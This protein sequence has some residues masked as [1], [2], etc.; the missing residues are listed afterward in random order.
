MNK[1]ILMIFILSLFLFPFIFNFVSSQPDS[2]TIFGIS[3]DSGVKLTE[4]WE[5]LGKNWKDMLMENSV[6]RGIDSFF[7]KIDPL[8]SILFGVEYSLSL[9][10]LFTILLWMYTF[11]L[12]NGILGNSLFSKWV[13]LAISLGVTI[14]IAQLKLFQISTNFIIGIFFGEQPWWA[15]VIIGIGIFA[16]LAILFVLVKNFGKQFAAS[17]KKLKEEKDRLKLHTGGV[18]GDALSKAVGGRK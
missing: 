11:F 1:K 5:S 3:P 17:R 12:F 4:K 6:V 15:K 8:F 7:Q 13:S 16:I 14:G 10:L 18:A 9:S 2:S